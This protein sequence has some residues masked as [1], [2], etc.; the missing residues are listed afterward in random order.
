MSYSHETYHFYCRLLADKICNEK[1]IPSIS[2]INRIIR[3][4]AILQRRCIEGIPVVDSDDVRFF[5]QQHCKVGQ[6]NII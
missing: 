3:D 4:K 1:N 5:L 6:G 2:S